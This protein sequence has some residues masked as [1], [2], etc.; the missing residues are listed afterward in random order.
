[1]I[2]AF[3]YMYMLLGVRNLDKFVFTYIVP[4]KTY[5]NPRRLPI[6]PNNFSYKNCPCYIN[7]LKRQVLPPKML[8]QTVCVELLWQILWAVGQ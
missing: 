2:F 6:I 8:K 5:Q 3:K 4:Q 7:I 1:M